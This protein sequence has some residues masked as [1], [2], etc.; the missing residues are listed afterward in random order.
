LGVD[1]TPTEIDI[2]WRIWD[3]LTS[4]P[5]FDESNNVF[6]HLA[7]LEGKSDFFAR[8]IITD[9]DGRGYIGKAPKAALHEIQALFLEVLEFVCR[10]LPIPVPSA[11]CLLKRFHRILV[12]GVRCGKINLSF[13]QL[14]LVFSLLLTH[15][16]VS[17]GQ[18]ALD[19]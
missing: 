8:R 19:F 5:F 1:I 7:V 13:L 18:I 16:H 4:T 9:T 12:F 11:R 2:L 3:F 17:L 14:G 15:D 6:F 10:S